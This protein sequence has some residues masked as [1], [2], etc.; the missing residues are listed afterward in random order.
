MTQ[1]DRDRYLS[2]INSI[3]QMTLKGK[4]RSKDQVF[5]MLQEGVDVSETEM[6]EACMGDRLTQ[7]Q[8]ASKTS[9]ELQQAK[10]TRSLR[11]LQTIQSEWERWKQ[12]NQASNVLA[13]AL[14]K[15][16]STPNGDR[17]SVILQWL[18]PNRDPTLTLAQWQEL[19][20]K[21]QQF[22]KLSGGESSLQLDQA[23]LNGIGEWQR[24]EPDL[25]SWVYDQPGRALGFEGV[26]QRGPWRL[27]GT[28]A[29]RPVVRSLFQHLSLERS[30][31]D[32]LSNSEHAPSTLDAGDILELAI[33]LRCIQQGLVA[34]FEK[35]VYDARLG[36]TLAMSSFLTFA[37][38]WSQLAIAVLQGRAVTGSATVLSDAC[39][40]ITLQILRSFAQRSYFPLYGGVFASFS[41][42]Y[43][44]DAL[45]Y[46]DEPLK[47]AEGTQEKARILT[48]LGYSARAMGNL[49]RATA[50]HH[51]A[52]DIAQT[53]GDRP[54]QIANL[55]HLARIA[56]L[57]Q[58][59]AE[60]IDF[61]QRAVIVSREAGD[62]LG[63]AN[64]LATLGYSEVFQ[65]QQLERMEAEI[66][67]SAIDRLLQGLQL[68][69]KLGD[70]QSQALCLSSAGLAYIALG[71]SETALQFL[72]QAI[73]AAQATGDTYLHAISFS[74]L[75]E[76]Q[77][78]LDN[79][80]AAMVAGG[81]GMYLLEQ[82]GSSLWRQPAN[83]LRVI[84]GRQGEDSF[85]TLLETQRPKFVAA[86]GV[87]GFD[88]LITLLTDSV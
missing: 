63:E 78:S 62:R 73:A 29:Q 61:S 2:L 1:P 25:M 27:W 47:R 86:I 68:A 54:C 5:Q 55:N 64:A 75:A 38:L 34:W 66:Y 12:D 24:I 87:D 72:E 17:L 10:A 21:M 9:D 43:L 51:Q 69:E 71:Q 44:R 26:G 74:Y 30:P 4:I 16:L 57:Q 8:T 76:A 48:L 83:L 88:H 40:Q 67:E 36:G 56:T 39:F 70:R 33:V 41:G 22:G 14:Q 28:K 23:I 7:F 81:L 37:V 79:L 31:L 13:D 77:L 45:D 50:L 18:D 20:K 84:R 59:Y 52:L 15:I 35:R 32:W 46:L 58:R 65:A 19:A 53:A 11:A 49:D 3:V 85:Q 6:F 82:I 60:A 42:Q 80:D